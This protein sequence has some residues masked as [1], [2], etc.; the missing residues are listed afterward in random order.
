MYNF[1][2]ICM[3]KEKTMKLW[4]QF[5]NIRNELLE[6]VFFWYKCEKENYSLS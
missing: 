6:N 5:L 2:F 1:I 3:V 4:S